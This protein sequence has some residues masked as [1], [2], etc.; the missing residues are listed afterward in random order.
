MRFHIIFEID[1]PAQ[2]GLPQSGKTVIPGRA[3]SV[4]GPAFHLPTMTQIG[5]GTLSE[6]RLPE[7]KLKA[8]LDD[9]TLRCELEDN[10]AQIKLEADSASEAHRQASAWMDRFLQHLAV[11]RRVMFSHRTLLIEDDAGSNHPIPRFR[12]FMSVT[13]YN[14]GTMKESILEA[15]A[16]SDLEDRRLNRAL[17]YYELALLIFGRRQL[18]ADILSRHSTN[19]ISSA[20]LNLWKAVTTVVGDPSRRADRHQRRYRMLG[21][22][23]SLKPKLDRLKEL[24]DGYDV[25]HYSLDPSSVKEVELAFGEAL[26]IVSEVLN[27][28]RAF[29]KKREAVREGAAPPS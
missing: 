1:P 28:Y 15:V 29:L 16:H 26:V 2:F 23:E 5:H 6:Y 3:G 17:E 22:D 13:A 4:F 18:V 21:F 24:R 11:S 9:G 12:E 10:I 14:L 19:I 8:C 25:A 27:E 20:F 7:D